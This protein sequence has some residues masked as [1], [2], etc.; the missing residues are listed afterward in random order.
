MSSGLLRKSFRA[1][2]QDPDTGTFCESYFF[3]V[4]P[5]L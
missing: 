1:R 4:F 3:I 5:T 2:A